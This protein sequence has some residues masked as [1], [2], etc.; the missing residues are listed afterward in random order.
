MPT[1]SLSAMLPEPAEFNDYV[2]VQTTQKS[3]IFKSGIIADMSAELG[4]KLEGATVVMPFFK[5]LDSSDL[6]GE[7]Q[8]DDTQDLT[9]D[10]IGTDKDIAV[11][12]LRGKAFGA[13]DL[14]GDLS[15][16][17]PL[18]SI[19]NRFADWWV[20]R[21]QIALLSVLKGAMGATGMAGNTLDISAGA[22]DAAKFDPDSFVDATFLLGDMSGG[23]TSLAVHSATLKAMVKYDM[24]ETLQD[25]QT[26]L[27]FNTYM[28]KRLIVDDS[29]PYEGTGADRV[30]TTYLF[31]PG[32]IGYASGSPKVPV[33]TDRDSLKLMGQEWIVNRKQWVMHPRGIRWVGTAAAASGPTNAELANSANWERVYDSKLIRLVAFKHKL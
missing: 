25:S 27:T 8:L 1:T 17:D 26:G 10:G 29:M 2:E 7:V 12:T 5:D 20:R 4:T 30:F 14:A 19:Q 18:T 13:T 6:H 15:S 32:S 22:G 23:L 3:E 33:E 9:V 16:A 28:G 21:Y 11:K 31:G 24:I